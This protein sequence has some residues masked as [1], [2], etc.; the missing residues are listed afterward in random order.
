MLAAFVD[1]AHW[2]DAPPLRFAIRG[3]ASAWRVEDGAFR[4]EVEL[5]PNVAG[6]VVLP[7]GEP[8]E[9]GPGRHAF[10]PVRLGVATG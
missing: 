10:G 6:P 8:V 1:D 2:A 4:L 9:V 3:F 7:G 5:P